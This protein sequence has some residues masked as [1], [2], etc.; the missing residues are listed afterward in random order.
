MEQL[1]DIEQQQCM[2]LNNIEQQHGRTTTRN[3]TT[4]NTTTLNDNNIERQ[5]HG[6]TSTWN[7]NV[8]QH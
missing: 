6:I 8:E 7:N 2:T 5:Q 3:T 4:W 1:H